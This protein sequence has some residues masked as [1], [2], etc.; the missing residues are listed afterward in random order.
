LVSPKGTLIPS[1]AEAARVGSE[2]ISDS[3]NVDWEGASKK[4][5]HDTKRP[6]KTKLSINSI[7][8]IFM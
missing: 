1:I 6:A 4:S 8:F 3:S 5:S 2:K 7:F